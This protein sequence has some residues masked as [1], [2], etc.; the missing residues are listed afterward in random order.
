MT[1]DRMLTRARD[2]MQKP[3]TGRAVRGVRA[4]CAALL[5][6][7]ATSS[8][9]G[10][11]GLTTLAFAQATPPAVEPSAM[12]SVYQTI[13]G[14]PNLTIAQKVEQKMAVFNATLE[15][16]KAYT[17]AFEDLTQYAEI[18]REV[19]GL[20]QPGFGKKLEEFQARLEKA[21]GNRA[22]KAVGALA[23]AQEHVA[24]AVALVSE[25][26]QILKDKNL[27]PAAKRSLA[28]LRGAGE[29]LSRLGSIPILGEGLAV[30]GN[31]IKELTGT[32]RVAAQNIEKLKGGNLSSAEEDALGGL[33]TTSR[34]YEKA[35]LYQHGLPAVVDVESGATYLKVP[36]R[37]WLAVEPDEV[38]RIFAEWKYLHKGQVPSAA[39]I[40]EYLDSTE[41]RAK[42][43]DDARLRAAVERDKALM[44]EVG[45]EGMRY[46][47]FLD[48]KALLEGKLKALGLTV[49][50][51][52]SAFRNLLRNYVAD[53]TA[54][55]AILKAK[56]LEAHPDAR[57]Y[58]AWLKLDPDT[59]SIE[60]LAR[61][62]KHYRE[63]GYRRFATA[64]ALAT[65]AAGKPAAKSPTDTA[66]KNLK[67]A[68]EKATTA[69][70]PPPNVPPPPKPA[71]TG[72]AIEPQAACDCITRWQTTVYKAQ[73]LA[74]CKQAWGS[75]CVDADV[76]VTEPWTWNVELK[77]CVGSYE[78][79]NLLAS[80]KGNW[81]VTGR[82]TKV[83][84][85]LSA[86]RERCKELV[87]PTPMKVD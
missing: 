47:D 52:S 79:K 1:T 21:T 58:L 48:Q 34:L 10:D 67:D 18:A 82:A 40:V 59:L 84:V 63:G 5:V 71:S 17:S 54:D 9:P 29:A 76:V 57:A 42:L 32:V 30:Y 77:M 41:A 72:A 64:Q 28:A 55:N 73:Q 25:V 83:R 6:V 46:S 11:S 4:A 16:G 19:G 87:T 35:P 60:D 27:P 80:Y 74:S 26:D 23:S 51:R 20:L 70:T 68:L 75:D 85:D 45:A 50:P 81:Q 7:G 8:S 49:S 56:A 43:G 33:P 39:D 53:P 36:D 13:D 66:G 61:H 38:S 31:V 44:A 37:P 22:F 15:A 65:I 69:N 12:D 78:L 62:L 2:P 14:Q 24:G 86:A 3:K